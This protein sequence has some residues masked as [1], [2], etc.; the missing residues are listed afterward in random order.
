LEK[1]LWHPAFCEA[2]KLE[3]Y[4]YRDV[5]EFQD[6]HQLTSGSL[7]I[8]CLIIKK[9]KDVAID[10]NIAHI[11]RNHNVF[12]YKSPEDS[13]DLHDFR[14]TYAYKL[15]YSVQNGIDKIE[16]ISVTLVAFQHPYKLLDYLRNRYNVTSEHKGIYVVEHE[17]VHSQIVVSSELAEDEN[18]WLTHL[19][20]ELTAARFFR[21]LTEAVKYRKDPALETYLD[22]VTGANFQ[23]FQEV[24]MGKVIDQCLQDLGFIDK[25][26]A[27]GKAEGR[28]E[29]R[30]EGKVENEAK[31]IIRILTRRL[32]PPPISLQNKIYSIRNIAKLDELADFALSCVSLEEFATALE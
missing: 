3:L 8:D 25:W 6:E 13:L 23:T 4:E 17:L 5:L 20:K 18:I 14:K 12:E 31:M 15:L 16:D 10:K 22:V 24:L 30:A 21:L 7:R 19:R 26:R 9:L 32:E 1:I 2:M 29:G 28:A 11:F 27:E